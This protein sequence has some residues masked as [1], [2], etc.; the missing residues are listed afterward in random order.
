MKRYMNH[1]MVETGEG[2]A[3]VD[4]DVSVLGGPSWLLAFVFESVAQRIR[5]KA[6]QSQLDCQSR[7]GTTEPF[8]STLLSSSL[9][10]HLLTDN[11][12][13][14]IVVYVF[15]LFCHHFFDDRR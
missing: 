2:D 8:I 10:A 7:E 3:L 6:R 12:P 4:Q 14:N 13:E 5:P 9:P 11:S 1:D 15:T